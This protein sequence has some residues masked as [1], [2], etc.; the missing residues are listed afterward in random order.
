MK[1]NHV[2]IKNE[3]AKIYLTIIIKNIQFVTVKEKGLFV[4]TCISNFI[5][6]IA[7]GGILS[8][9]SPKYEV[10][11]GTWNTGAKSKLSIMAWPDLTAVRKYKSSISGEIICHKNMHLIYGFKN[12]VL[13][14]AEAQ[15]NL[16]DDLVV[17]P[18]ITHQF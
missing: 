18:P 11:Q 13:L 5:C 6:R 4:V 7:H 10:L 3:N 8:V 1:K 12:T 14:L 15:K 2:S 17:T 16:I 9:N